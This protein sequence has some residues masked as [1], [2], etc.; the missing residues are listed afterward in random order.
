[1]QKQLFLNQKHIEGKSAVDLRTTG[2]LRQS[3]ALSSN[4]RAWDADAS[5]KGTGE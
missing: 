4:W 1:M 3:P 2:N 5:L